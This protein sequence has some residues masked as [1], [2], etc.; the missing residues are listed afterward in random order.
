MTVDVEDFFHVSAFNK[1]LKQDDWQNFAPRVDKNTRRLLDL[2]EETDSTATFFVLGWVAEKYP[3]LVREIAHRGHEVASHGYDHRLATEQSVSEF[4]LDVS[5]SKQLLEE[6]IGK[7]IKG[8]RAPSFSIGVHNEWVYEELVDMGFKYSSS[9]YPI[10]HDLY[11]VPDWPRFCH[12]R[13]EGIIEIPISTLAGR[14]GNTGIGGGGY[15]RLYPY[16][17]SKRRINKFLNKETHPYNF[18]FHPW[19]ID[20]E[21]P[22]ITGASLKS[23]FRHYINLTKMEGKLLRLTKDYKWATME[24]VF[25]I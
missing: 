19:E 4:R 5:R 6:V 24:Q 17:F 25:G 21:Q 23:R 2:F 15:F 11:G 9:T 22:R 7:A 3:E 20:P 12:K 1:V 10:K 18:Y 16:W 13:K 14:G 8:Y